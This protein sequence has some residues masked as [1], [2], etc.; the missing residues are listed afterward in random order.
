MSKPLL[1]AVVFLVALLIVA[2]SAAAIYYSQ[3]Q[4]QASE[5]QKYINELNVALASYRSLSSDYGIALAKYN[6]TISLLADAVANLNTS[7]PSYHEASAALADLW[8]SYLTLSKNSSA[9]ITYSARML[10]DFGNGTRQ[11][12]NGTRTQPG[13][14]AYVATVVLLGGRVQ[15]SWYPQYQEHFV[16]GLD[17]VNSGPSNSWFVWEYGK[18]GWQVSQTGADGIQVYNGTIFAWTLCGYDSSF[19]PTCTP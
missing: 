8:S 15:A 18:S 6:A 2:S 12:V 1:A 14:N 5:K 13:W 17:G 16:E 11:W 10:V 9:S 4:Q 7:T 19:N 3:Y